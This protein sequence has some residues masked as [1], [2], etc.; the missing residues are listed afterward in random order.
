MFKISVIIPCYN[1]SK[2]I[3]R[4]LAS[5]V[6]QTIGIDNL[7]IICV[8]DASTDDTWS[9]LQE[10]EQK[11][12]DHIFLIRLE[13]NNRQGTCRNIA[14]QYVK[15]P[16]VAFIDADDWVEPDYCEIMYTYADGLQCDVVCCD[17]G[18]DSSPSLS[19]FT[20]RGDDASYLSIDTIEKRKLLLMTDAIAPQVWS[21]LVRTN[22][23]VENNIYFAENIYYEDG[24]WESLFLMYVKSAMIL[25]TRLYHYFYNP[26]STVL[27]KDS[28]HHLDWLSTMILKWKEW[29]GRGFF[30]LYRPELEYKFYFECYLGFFRLLALRYTNPP[31]SYY[32]LLREITLNYIPDIYS[33]PYFAGKLNDF[34][35]LLLP[36][37][38]S[39]LS[40]KEFGLL[41]DNAR[42]YMSAHIV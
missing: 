8:D 42:R 5:I 20:D 26:S 18:R 37:L 11:Y 34:Q 2:Y 36:G 10:F 41:V 3:D 4:C 6:N 27:S 38:S 29:I 24:L 22:L 12:S 9:H 31:Y 32:L 35:E 21:K 40:K 25:K 17:Y 15:A 16:W 39:Q 28:V 14:M 33:N 30:N 23:L 13:T 19:F 1:V 7:Q